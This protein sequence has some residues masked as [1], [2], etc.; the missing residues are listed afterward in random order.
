[1]AGHQ[2]P[3]LAWASLSPSPCPPVSGPNGLAQDRTTEAPGLQFRLPNPSPSSLGVRDVWPGNGAACAFLPTARDTP[4]SELFAQPETQGLH[5]PPGDT[6]SPA[7]VF[8]FPSL[9]FPGLGSMPQA[10][11]PKDPILSEATLSWGCTYQSRNLT[12]SLCMCPPHLEAQMPLD[13][14]HSTLRPP[15]N[16]PLYRWE[17]RGPADVQCGCHCPTL[18][19]AVSKE[20]S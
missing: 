11:P 1:M 20:S 13:C 8:T 16:L 10:V 18:P 5:P 6:P 2:D 12:P 9:S 17:N 3:F 4:F 14:L 7:S 15:V 19:S